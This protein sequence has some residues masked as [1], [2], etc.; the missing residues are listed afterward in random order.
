MKGIAQEGHV[1]TLN[2]SFLQQYNLA[3]SSARQALKALLEKEMIYEEL[4]I[5]TSNY[6]VYDQFLSRWMAR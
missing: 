6:R 1:S 4:D 3:E 2:A 5:I